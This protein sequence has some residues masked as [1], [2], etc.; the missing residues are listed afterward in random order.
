[1][2]RCETSTTCRPGA[3][4]LPPLAGIVRGLLAR[5]SPPAG[6]VDMNVA[7]IG[8]VPLASQEKLS[9]P[10]FIGNGRLPELP[11]EDWT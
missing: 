4:P 7:F 9:L 1:A 8:V 5:R 3:S 2:T 11:R 6:A 10:S